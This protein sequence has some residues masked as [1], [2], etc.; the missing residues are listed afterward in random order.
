M[1]ASPRAGA[2]VAALG[3]RYGAGGDVPASS[4]GVERSVRFTPWPSTRRLLLPGKPDPARAVLPVHR[5]S[6]IA[7]DSAPGSTHGVQTALASASAPRRTS[8]NV[9]PSWASGRVTTTNTVSGPAL[10]SST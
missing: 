8:R 2:G 10:V 9:V 4:G 7:R 1:A 6:V 3:H 5:P